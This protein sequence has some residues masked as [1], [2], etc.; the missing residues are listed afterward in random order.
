MRQ[1]R[2]FIFAL[3][4]VA[5]FATA[6]SK[7][8]SKSDA[9]NP[10]H[11]KP[12]EVFLEPVTSVGRN[13]FTKSVAFAAVPNIGNGSVPGSASGSGIRS[14]RGSTSGLYAG[15]G[16]QPVCDATALVTLLGDSGDKG[17][18]WV[19]GLNSDSTLQWSG[20]AKLSVDDVTTFV[21]ELT[22]VF[23]RADTRLTGHGLLLGHDVPYQS[24]LQKGTAV[25]VD[26]QGVPRIRCASGSPLTAPEPAA[27]PKYRGTEWAGFSQE[28]LVIVLPATTTLDTLRIVDIH[29]QEVIEVSP[30]SGCLCDRTL[31]TTTTSTTLFDESAT[32]TTRK[33]GVTTTTRRTTTTGVATTTSAPTTTTPTPTTPTTAATATP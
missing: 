33:P 30:G 19:D 21:T 12:G 26:A 32:T 16:S 18:A 17:Q 8:S 22:S 7:G 31:Q 25:L 4:A 1:S 14:V 24:V 9:G 20:G 15:S 6:C 10:G 13:P 5:F 3:V 27:K 29:T 28:R 11:P 23:V 2:V